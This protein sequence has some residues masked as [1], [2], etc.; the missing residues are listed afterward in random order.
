MYVANDISMVVVPD[1][2]VN[3]G[4]IIFW[5]L[6]K[7]IYIRITPD[8]TKNSI[9]GL[10]SSWNKSNHWKSS[11]VGNLKLLTETS[12]KGKQIMALYFELQPYENWME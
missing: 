5:L 7:S 2:F 8:L 6:S 4:T 9:C 10:S 11:L 12:A 1:K 3:I